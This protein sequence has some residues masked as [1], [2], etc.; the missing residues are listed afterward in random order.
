[1]MQEQR[2]R[3]RWDGWGKREWRR[4]AVWKQRELVW[5][6]GTV[7]MIWSSDLRGPAMVCLVKGEVSDVV[8]AVLKFAIRS[9]GVRALSRLG[10]KK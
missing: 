8:I 5:R 2:G 10:A 1:M 6:H 7:R 3:K 9:D 4:K